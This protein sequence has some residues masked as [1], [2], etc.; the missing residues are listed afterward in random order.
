MCLKSLYHL[1]FISSTPS[2]T[3]Q[4]IYDDIYFTGKEEWSTYFIPFLFL[5]SMLERKNTKTCPLWIKI[6]L[7]SYHSLQGYL[8]W[9]LSLESHMIE[10][11]VFL[12][13]KLWTVTKTGFSVWQASR[14]LTTY[15]FESFIPDSLQL[16]RKLAA[17]K[18]YFMHSM[19]YMFEPPNSDTTK[20]ILCSTLETTIQQQPHLKPWGLKSH[21]VW[22]L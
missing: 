11:F 12:F 3:L 15:R 16:L 6:P 22:N 8:E 20:Y 18:L 19:F 9:S 13:A 14:Q 1:F 10:S 2:S 17:H 7:C 4:N 5:S 21:Q